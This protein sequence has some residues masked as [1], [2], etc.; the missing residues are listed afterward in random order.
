VLDSVDGLREDE[1]PVVGVF[2]FLEVRRPGVVVDSVGDRFRRVV[3]LL[4]VLIC[5]FVVTRGHTR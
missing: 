5:V 2:R 3:T 1:F 4:G